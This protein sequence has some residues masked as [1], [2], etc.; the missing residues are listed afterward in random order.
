MKL[1]I[2]DGQDV[3]R[4]ERICHFDVEQS[5]RQEDVLQVVLTFRQTQEYDSPVKAILSLSA[6]DCGQLGA[7]LTKVH[8]LSNIPGLYI[9]EEGG[10]G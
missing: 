5:S 10:E 3:I 6:F 7:V 2:K 9:L 4:S 8:P 1:E